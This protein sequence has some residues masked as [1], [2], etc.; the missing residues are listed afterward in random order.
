LAVTENGASFGAGS[1]GWSYR[2]REIAGRERERARVAVLYS[3][4]IVAAGFGAWIRDLRE[5]SYEVRWRTEQR[6]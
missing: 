2:G 1:R 6:K 5:D 3:G 4:E